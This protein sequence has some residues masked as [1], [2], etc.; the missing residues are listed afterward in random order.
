LVKESVFSIKRLFAQNIYI[1]ED[2]VR[3]SDISCEGVSF[4]ALLT[5]R[6][7]KSSQSYFTESSSIHNRKDNKK[8]SR[9]IVIAMECSKF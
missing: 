4:E 1:S 6:V 8:Q 2:T 9:E 3:I 7:T 5:L